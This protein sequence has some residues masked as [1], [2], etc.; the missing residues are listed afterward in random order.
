MDYALYT[1]ISMTMSN[2]QLTNALKLVIGL[3]ISIIMISM[4]IALFV[5]LMMISF[6]IVAHNCLYYITQR[7]VIVIESRSQM[8][9]SLLI[10]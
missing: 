4:S 2:A 9:T 10:T 8:L 5:A 7:M 3:S 1:K 6:L